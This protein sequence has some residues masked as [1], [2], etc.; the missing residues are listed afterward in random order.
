MTDLSVDTS[1]YPKPT[2]P[3][4]PLDIASKLGGIQQQSLQI[5]QAKA[6]QANQALQYLTRALGAIGPDG[7][8]DQYKN[9]AKDAARTF[10]IPT[11]TLH[12]WDNKVD[13]SFATTGSGK[14]FWNEAINTGRQ[15]GETLNSYVP[16]PQFINSGAYTTAVRTPQMGRPSLV[17]S[18]ENQVP[19]TQGTIDASGQPSTI[20]R[21]PL[22]QTPGFSNRLGV[23]SPQVPFSNALI[24]PSAVPGMR[25]GERTVNAQVMPAQS[26]G[27][28]P[29]GLPPGEATLMEAGAT[30]L[31]EDRRRATS[32]QR[33]VFPLAQ[34]IPALEKL[35]PKGTGPG[36]ET[37]NQI[38]SFILS[39]VPG[40]KES[41]VASVKTFDEAKKY[42]TDFVNQTGNSGTNDKLAAAFA[43]NPSVGISNAAATDVAKSALAL[44]RMQQAM[45]LEFETQKLPASQY[46]RWLAQKV[47]QTDP[48][49]F[50]IDLMNNDTK[51]KL[52]D[53]IKKNPTE[54]KR[55]EDSLN[56][57]VNM[58]FITPK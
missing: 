34:A 1:S 5:N 11:D 56:L 16:N 27:G 36:T 9:A 53:Q 29:T 19:P 10:N 33:D 7:T 14:A 20:G 48:R 13:N 2:L 28:V 30:Q 24:S 55:F 3:V 54:A 31:A 26:G 47:Q 38:K 43:G 57:A 41:D 32:F 45:Y 12:V 35:G 17:G 22:P 23:S 52:R 8:A 4:S 15:H 42:L 40:I 39:N 51:A 44:R 37:I 21:Q 25:P 49:A 18:I 46:S 6:D 58:G 50:G